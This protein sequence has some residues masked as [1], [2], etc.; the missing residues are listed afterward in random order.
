MEKTRT[1]AI[2]NELLLQETATLIAEGHTVTHLVRGNSMSPFMV[3][4]RDKVVLSPF[5]ADELVPGAV[6]L[7]RDDAN[8]LVLHRIIR[9]KGTGLTLMGDG[10]IIGTEETSTDRVM[11]LVSAVIRK[12]KTYSCSGR[13]WRTYSYIWTRLVPVRKYLLGAWRAARRCAQ[14]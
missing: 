9:R 5:T 14:V 10:N 3:D 12:K 8:R 2:P 13:I 6:V 4:R 11:G 1:K 7:A